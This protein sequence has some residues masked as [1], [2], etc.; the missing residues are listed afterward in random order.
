[1]II[2]VVCIGHVQTLWAGGHISIFHAE[3]S[4]KLKCL[5]LYFSMANSNAQTVE[6]Q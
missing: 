2:C 3:F 4:L 6:Q 1:M 5:T